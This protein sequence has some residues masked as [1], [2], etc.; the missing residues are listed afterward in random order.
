MEPTNNNKVYVLV[1]GAVII[2]GLL[3]YFFGR[4]EVIAVAEDMT[5][6][7]DYVVEKGT[8]V[9]VTD[10][11]VITV[12]GN[13]T[14][15]GEIAGDA[16]GVAIIAKGN[17]TFDASAKII[18]NG[19]VQI[20]GDTGS[21][22]DTQE[23]IDA[24]FDEAGADTGAGPRVGP[25]AP[26]AGG[27]ASAGI[28][29]YTLNTETKDAVSSGVVALLTN[30]VR[31]ASAQGVETPDTTVT[32]SGTID[33][34][35][36]DSADE[37]SRKKIIILSFPPSAGKVQMNLQ[38]L[39]IV[40][41]QNTPKGTDDKGTSCNAKGGDGAN[42]LRLRGSAWGIEI[43]NFNVTL[44][45]GGDGGDA[46]TKGDCD[47]GTAR[48]GM[49]GDSGNMKLT[50]DNSFKIT[51]AFHLKPGKSGNGGQATA[52]GKDGA[53]SGGKG[54]DANAYG[55]KGKDNT[56]ELSVKGAVEGMGNIT[57]DELLGGDGG[58]AIA[59]GGNGGGN[60]GC[61]KNGGPG[62]AATAEGGK[63]GS[64]SLIV[65]GALSPV[66]DIGGN[67]GNADAVGGSGGNGGNCDSKGKGG[68]GGKGGDAHE[69]EGKGGAGDTAG[70]DGVAISDGGNG[71]NGGSGCPEGAGGKG[72]IGKT[73]GTDGE[74]GK[75]L[76]VEEKKETFVDPGREKVKVI[77]YNG[78]YLPVDQ[79]IIE[80]EVGCGAEHWH[81]AE[82]VVKA[83]D[84]TM[85]GDP[86]PQC[87]YGKVREKPVMEIS[88]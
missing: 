65:L 26:S 37:K 62:G 61:A 64:A 14:I 15:A 7:G 22:A 77:N 63:G 24:M 3:W 35:K 27:T 88:L 56:K 66:F 55:G 50:A 54:G 69:K 59:D 84:G 17:V 43:N 72:G 49:G 19:N 12:E 5:V 85:V 8:R 58:N 42:G 78:K 11:A 4:T 57:I 81:A 28:A 29:P 68:N 31:T 41:P 30:T 71:G 36:A 87:G 76:C 73:P 70:T 83:T 46:E 16:K 80:N 53:N 67:G 74:K 1:A 60:T 40:G 13:T 75:N 48:G 39:T 33:L 10:G 82:G 47:P 51:G 79:L 23:K 86:G 52:R 32:L 18:S 6:S 21:L 9:E 25:F 45:K 2:A 34:S 38:D 20:V 44:A